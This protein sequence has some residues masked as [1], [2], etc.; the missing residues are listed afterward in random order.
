M[1]LFLDKIF[2]KKLE[3]IDELLS[4]KSTNQ[5]TPQTFLLYRL[6]Y[7]S[8]GLPYIL[9]ALEIVLTKNG[10]TKNNYTFNEIEFFLNG[11]A[12]YNLRYFTKKL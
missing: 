1:S 7:W 5:H 8:Y 9:S 6:Y 2:L 3:I 11:H 12:I 4:H 10:L